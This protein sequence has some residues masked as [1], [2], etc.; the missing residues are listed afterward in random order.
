VILVDAI[1]IKEFRG[2]R[3]LTLSFKGKNFAVCG[4]NGTGK[5]GVVDALEFALTGNV[6]RLSGEGKGEVSLKQHGPHVDF[7]NNPDKARV[8]VTLTIPS[9]G[10]IVTIERS[11]K[12][13]NLAQVTPS[14]PDVLALLAGVAAHPEI[15]LSRREL[16]RYVLATP[17]D[18]AREVQ[19]LLHL[20]R[21][22]DVRVGLQ[23]IANSAERQLPALVAA[24]KM[25]G[26]SLLRALAITEL[27]AEK[28]LA[29]TNTQ[30]AILGLPALTELTA[31]TSLKDGLGAP[32]AAKPQSIPKAQAVADLKA[33][34]DALD[35]LAA[36]TLATR[37]AELTTD[38]SN[39][40]ANGVGATGVTVEN[41]Y[42]TGLSLIETEACPLCDT[43]WDVAELRA[44]L[45]A[46]LDGL[47]EF[48]RQR[49]L[50][51]RKIGP[52]NATLARVRASLET[53]ARHA[54]LATPPLP[55][56]AATDFATAC[57]TSSMQLNAL[58]PLPDTIAV[59]DRVRTEPPEV[60]AAITAL[61][62]VVTA[63]PEPGKQD[64]ARDYLT[65]AQERLET[66]REARRKHKAASEQAVL[67]R[68][69]S[70]TYV[71]TSDA[72][73]IGLYAEVQKD[74]AALYRFIN[75]NDENA[76]TAKLVPSIGKLG[77]DVDFY[78][79]GFF[80]PGAYHSEGHQD[81]MGLCLYLALMRHL[82]GP[83]FTFAVLD[84]VLMSVDTGHRREV[85]ALLK[86]EFSHTQFIVTTHDPVWLRHMK[87][88]GLLG[89]KNGVQFRK[90]SV[91]HGPAEWH[92]RDVWTEIDE[93]LQQNDVRSAAALLRH[94]L[95]YTGSELCHRL[96]VPV[97]YRYDGQ[98]QLGELLPPA[99]AHLR[100]LYKSAKEIASG[101]NQKDTVAALAAR[102]AAFG[103]AAQT[104]QV[105]QW[106][107]NVA[108]HF[109][110]WE[111]LKKEDFVPVV[112][113]Y[114]VLLAAFTCEKCGEYLH[115]SPDRETP[116]SLR[117]D[118]G[119]TT[120]NLKKR[121]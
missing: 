112:K 46:K 119:Q 63:L 39:L 26:E 85:C 31:T 71:A 115:V 20:D 93:Y 33:A 49:K 34:R 100:K 83:N 95:E 120:I 66:W 64:S 69:I 19:A 84:D 2:I 27:T 105:E 6:S 11:A 32:T 30:R 73:L 5:S 22:E 116:E 44:K 37:V 17:G 89:G 81:G 12:T 65:L 24:V 9:L 108:V 60:R 58:L 61:E 79:R 67:A 90:W 74:F 68:K 104:S 78:G 36:P 52:L 54:A 113:A 72:L 77:F 38:V 110:S 103:L 29:V 25:A 45:Q 96:R 117:C 76:F 99:I 57:Q 88:V 18:R 43:A 50:I 106:Q 14:T 51:E 101:W 40:A 53:L 55:L 97:E 3:D 28:L 41:F 42:T 13:P 75:K 15:V 1:T 111:N 7:R 91:E 59:L 109:N 70:D 92:D 107:V 62:A 21:V 48:S 47:A 82:Q 118:C 23:K 102:E 80:P 16:I 4:P 8:S 86:Q 10:K 121:T 94:F 87:T 56:T 114:Q 35:E 98:Y